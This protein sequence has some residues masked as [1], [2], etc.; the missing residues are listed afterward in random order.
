MT[1]LAVHKHRQQVDAAIQQMEELLRIESVTIEQQGHVARYVCILVYGVLENGIRSILSQFCGVR[2]LP[3]KRIADFIDRSLRY[4]PSPKVKNIL[5]QLGGFDAEWEKQMEAFLDGKI[6]DH[7]SSIVNNRNLI[8][9]GDQ[10]GISLGAAK[11][12]YESVKVFLD[13]L[14]EITGV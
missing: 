8:A 10:V 5:Q 9:H 3:H 14:E 1:C 13:K 11:T 2:V 4:A 7:I 12:Y 6:G